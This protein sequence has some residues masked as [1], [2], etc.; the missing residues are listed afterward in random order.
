MS[1]VLSYP[2]INGLY[3]DWAR[4]GINFYGI[5]GVIP[6]AIPTKGFRSLSYKDRTNGELVMANAQAPMGQTSGQVMAEQ[7]SITMLLP[8]YQQLR[9]AICAESPQ[10][11]LGALSG[12]NV[13]PGFG[14]YT[15]LFNMLIRY[16]GVD[17]FGNPYSVDDYL[18]GCRMSGADNSHRSGGG[19][20]E[21]SFPFQP[22]ILCL[23]GNFPND[24]TDMAELV[25]AIVNLNNSISI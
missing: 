7:G 6:L 21:V 18:F 1:A 10:T 25:T 20:L 16:G 19:A 15:T 11:P 24:D 22:T 8:E 17:G 14:A 9:D 5:L 3:P 2:N 4:I 12:L 13:T 23:G